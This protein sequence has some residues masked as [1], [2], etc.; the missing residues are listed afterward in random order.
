MYGM[1]GSGSVVFSREQQKKLL[2]AM[3]FWR[4]EPGHLRLYGRLVGF[5][6]DHRGFGGVVIYKFEGVVVRRDF[7]GID[8]RT[9]RGVYLG[10][11]PAPK[12]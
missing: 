1:S 6:S 3:T 12:H 4:D 5:A 7:M 11:P 9:G 2:E 8:R 10:I